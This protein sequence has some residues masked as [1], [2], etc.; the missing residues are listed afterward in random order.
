M[1]VT[2]DPYTAADLA[3]MIPEIWT[4]IIG[5]EM[6]A[7]TVAA[8]FFTDLSPYAKS[9]GDIFHIPDVFTNKFSIQTQSVQ[10]AEVTT[11]SV[12]QVD[13]TLTVNLHKYI[14]MLI[15][16]KDL[17]QISSNYSVNAVYAK[18]IG[19]TLAN[20]LE[21]SLF[22]LWTGL[23]TNSAG[24]TSTVLA[25]LELRQAIG[26]LAAEN[27]DV[28]SKAA[29]F[30]HPNIYWSQLAGI[31]KYY[32][33]SVYGGPSMVRSGSFGPMD[34]SRGLVGQIYGIPIYTST[35][36]T[37]GLGTYRNI[38]AM[39]EAFGFAIQTPGNGKVR[40][41]A[42]NQI[43]NLG[44]LTVTDIIYGVAEL[45]DDA[46]VAVNANISATLS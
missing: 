1:A 37:S 33:A 23:S 34:F 20:A 13:R 10:G 11:E 15:G 38:L 24:D 21:A 30:V 29:L 16:D 4:P 43:R 32:D 2:T 31:Q 17:Q 7:K 36:V 22:A 12:A 39:P 26:L 41:Q 18:K 40:V 28:Q 46:A 25:D 42:E 3:A 8:N 5:E 6:F 45:R 27:F 44:M 19:S 9:G 14:A 35:N